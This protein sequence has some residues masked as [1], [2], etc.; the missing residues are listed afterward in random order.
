LI[1]LLLSILSS[2]GIFIL[3]KLFKIYKINT[4]QAIVVNYIAAFC[5]G[6]FIYNGEI[7]LSEIVTANRFLHAFILSLLFISI[8]NVMALTAQKNGLSVVSVASKMS[9]IIPIVFG[10]VVLD[11]SIGVQ[12]LLVWFLL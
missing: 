9:V 8:F 2:T 1:Y 12:K 6:L 4:L 3:F 11:E 10:I 7:I 5:S